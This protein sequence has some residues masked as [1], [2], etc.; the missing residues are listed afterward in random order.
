MSNIPEDGLKND[1]P[2]ISMADITEKARKIAVAWME[3]DDKR[4]I[5]NKHK[6]ASDIMNYARRHSQQ[7]IEE[8]ETEVER[9]KG[10]IEKAFYNG[11]KTIEYRPDQVWQHFKSQNNL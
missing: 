2:L 10:L 4:W 3:C 5:G 1:Y 8:L 11:R 6:L 9:L 7:K